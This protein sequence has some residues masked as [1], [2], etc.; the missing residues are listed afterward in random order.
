MEQQQSFSHGLLYSVAPENFSALH[1]RNED[2][3][4]GF[5]WDEHESQLEGES[6][7]HALYSILKITAVKWGLGRP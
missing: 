1:L 3:L 6:F 4:D 2:K 5:D 7:A